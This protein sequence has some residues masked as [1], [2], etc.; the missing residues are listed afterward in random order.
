MIGA[1]GG[2]A[3]HRDS[4]ERMDPKKA[5]A[6]QRG[7]TL[8]ELLISMAVFLIGMM[9]I[10]G[11][12]IASA[13][14]S[15][16]AQNSSIATNLGSSMLEELRVSDFGGLS[17]G[18]RTYRADGSLGSP[19]YFTV[20]WTVSGLA[21]KTIDLTVQ[22]QSSTAARSLQFSTQVAQGTVMK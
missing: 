17:N 11:M 5:K 16:D 15:R 19:A 13:R 12:Q 10:L 7:F 9:G 14:S 3:E 2:E 22:W 4:E 8:I 20:S 21:P 1:A 6:R 18:S